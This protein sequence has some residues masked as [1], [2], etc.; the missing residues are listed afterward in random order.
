[1]REAIK[2]HTGQDVRGWM[3]PWMS[4]SHQTPELLVETGYK[5]VMD[6]PADDQ[7]LWMRTRQGPLMSVPYPL[8]INDSP[9]M[10]VRRHTPQDFEHMIIEQFEEML[11]QSTRQ[12]LVFGIALHTMIVGQPYRLR[13]LRRALKYIARHPQRDRLWFTRPGEIYDHCAALPPAILPQP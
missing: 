5:F 2:R 11:E 7:P 12:P 3:G 13:S 10:L 4:Q 8:E 6:W 1:V 9:Q